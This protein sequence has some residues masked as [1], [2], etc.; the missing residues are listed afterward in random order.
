MSLAC[1]F[2][3]AVA[4]FAFWGEFLNKSMPRFSTSKTL[5]RTSCL[6]IHSSMTQLLNL[7]VIPH[8]SP[9]LGEN[10]PVIDIRAAVVK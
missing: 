4:H 2:T 9:H 10:L 5:R 1:W 3:T 6:G 7:R 8:V